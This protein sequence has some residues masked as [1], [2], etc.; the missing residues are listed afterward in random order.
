LATISVFSVGKGVILYG[1][2]DEVSSMSS[3]TPWSA[4][5]DDLG[6]NKPSMRITEDVLDLPTA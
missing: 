3:A 5:Y 6:V 1:V 2:V 4:K